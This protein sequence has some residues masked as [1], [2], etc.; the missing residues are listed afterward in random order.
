[1]VL[2]F[3]FELLF[4][5][6]YTMITIKYLEYLPQKLKKTIDFSV[7][8]NKKLIF[9]STGLVIY[10][11]NIFGIFRTLW[12]YGYF[13]LSILIIHESY[14]MIREMNSQVI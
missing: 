11:T 4:Y 10:L 14:H 1:M 5:F 9:L 12:L 13:L 8:L 7:L 3:G 6:N 2:T